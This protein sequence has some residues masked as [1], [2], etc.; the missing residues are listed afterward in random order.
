MQGEK[1]KKSNMSGI[2]KSQ[3]NNN[4]WTVGS[5]NADFYLRLK[6]KRILPYTIVSFAILINSFIAFVAYL[7][8]LCDI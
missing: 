4:D 3:T 8:D 6:F 5:K 1:K 2:V 7:S